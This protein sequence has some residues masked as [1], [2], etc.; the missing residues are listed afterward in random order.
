MSYLPLLIPD[1]KRHL[2]ELVLDENGSQF[3]KEDDWWFEAEGGVLMKWHWPIGLLYDHYSTSVSPAVA[4][5][6]TSRNHFLP[7]RITLHLAAPPTDK[8]LLGPSLEACKQAFMGQLKEADF[9]RSVAS[10]FASCSHALT[11]QPQLGQHKARD[12]LEETRTGRFVGWRARTYATRG[13]P[14]GPR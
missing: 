1:I 6:S 3:L 8:L 7:F 12:R 14:S 9:L 11:P 4:S 10:V 13:F 2:A 5:A